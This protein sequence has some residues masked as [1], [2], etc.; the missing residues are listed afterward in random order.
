MG[1]ASGRNRWHHN[2]LIITCYAAWITF[3]AVALWALLQVRETLVALAIL[4]GVAAKLVLVLDRWSVV[5]LGM[6]WIIIIVVMENY[7]STGLRAGRSR[8]RIR[9]VAVTEVGILGV[10]YVLQWLL[11][12]AAAPT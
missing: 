12:A 4:T 7:L 10:L 8:E 3:S 6:A 9:R 11:L 2:A 5:P 1:E